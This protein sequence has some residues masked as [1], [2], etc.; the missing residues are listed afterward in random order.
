MV[1]NLSRWL[2]R[3][4]FCIS[5]LRFFFLGMRIYGEIYLNE[6]V[7]FIEQDRRAVHLG[8]IFGIFLKER[9][10]AI[11]V[12]LQNFQLDVAEKWIET[13]DQSGQKNDC[14]HLKLTD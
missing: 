8:N 11:E 1:A 2:S 3:P 12:P 7:I 9:S 14:Y 5:S 10:E 4:P 13:I 6:L